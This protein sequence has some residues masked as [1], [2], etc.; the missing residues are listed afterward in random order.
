M[1]ATRLLH[2][3]LDTN[4]IKYVFGNPGTTETSILSSLSKY[5]DLNNDFEYILT[6]QESTTIGIAAG[7][8]LK[9]N[10]PSIVNIHT[11]P[12]LANSIC[13]MYNALLSQIPLLIISGQQNT[14][15]LI[16]NPSL[17]GPL[18]QLSQTASKYSYEITNINEF[19]IAL[20][21]CYLQSQMHP[22]GPT[23]LSIPMNILTDDINYNDTN[24]FIYKCNINQD[25]RNN[26]LKTLIDILDENR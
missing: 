16:H 26:N 7:Y 6:L 12:G 2:R 13:N 8:A 10:K 4:S 23:F 5:K 19:D 20:Q 22:F 15:N 11:F 18:L 24:N 3:F 14:N 1:S 21:R 25:I 9:T 17:S